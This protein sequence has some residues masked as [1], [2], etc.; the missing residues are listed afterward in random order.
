MST[1]RK[2]PSAVG[3]PRC[4]AGANPSTPQ[5]DP[6]AR[7]PNGWISPAAPAT[8]RP[9]TPSSAPLSGWL[10]ARLVL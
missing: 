10:F 7:P 1:L 5:T 4:P 9:L 3:S 6:D 2:R 8:G